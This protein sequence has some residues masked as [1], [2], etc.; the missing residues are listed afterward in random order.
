MYRPPRLLPTATARLDLWMPRVAGPGSAARVGRIGVLLLLVLLFRLFWPVFMPRWV[1]VLVS[2]L[3]EE[4]VAEHF[5]LIVRELRKEDVHPNAVFALDDLDG[6]VR[7]FLPPLGHE[8]EQQIGC[9]GVLFRDHVAQ[10]DSQVPERS[11]VRLHLGVVA[12]RFRAR[13][14]AAGSRVDEERA[15]RPQHDGAS[16]PALANPSPGW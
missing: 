11:V 6:A 9:L 5:F 12:P 3:T 8:L 7:L 13:G 1:T 10:V 15:S 4:A 14:G 16:H 2:E